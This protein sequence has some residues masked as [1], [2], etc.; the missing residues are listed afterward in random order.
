MPYEWRKEASIVILVVSSFVD[1]GVDFFRFGIF[2]LGWE[3]IELV[4]FDEFNRCGR[5]S[6]VPKKTESRFLG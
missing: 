3:Q 1:F 2:P 4:C 5:C 6:G